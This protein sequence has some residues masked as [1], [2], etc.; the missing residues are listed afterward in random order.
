M[1]L[2]TLYSQISFAHVEMHCCNYDKG[3]HYVIGL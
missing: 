2:G 3:P 1:Y